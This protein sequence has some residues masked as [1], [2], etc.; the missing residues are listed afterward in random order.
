MFTLL[1]LENILKNHFLL[2]RW[3]KARLS[4]SRNPGVADFVAPTSNP[5]RL[6]YLLTVCAAVRL[7][8]FVW[9]PHAPS[10]KWAWL[11]YHTSKTL[12]AILS[13]LI[14]AFDHASRSVFVSFPSWE[15]C[16][17]RNRGCRAI[18][19]LSTAETT[20][21]L[22]PVFFSSLREKMLLWYRLLGACKNNFMMNFREEKKMKGGF[23]SCANRRQIFDMFPKPSAS[24]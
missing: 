8:G 17:E 20:S 14:T 18:L 7:S 10:S 2:W 13:P 12:S 16:C 24:G 15:E 9:T 21:T 23:K 22:S 4:V 3:H 6:L 11:S 1:L 19:W 5:T